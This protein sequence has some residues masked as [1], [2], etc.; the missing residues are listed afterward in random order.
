MSY[1]RLQALVKVQRYSPKI[2]RLM[3]LPIKPVTC[4]K[5]CRYING[6]TINQSNK[7]SGSI[8]D[9]VNKSRQEL[10]SL[11]R[12]QAVTVTFSKV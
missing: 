11:E 4:N 7:I 10:F 12:T 9:H 1:N 2:S 6:Q 8:L 5:Q 3:L